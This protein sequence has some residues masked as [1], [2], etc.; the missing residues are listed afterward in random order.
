MEYTQIDGRWIQDGQALMRQ[1]SP[2]KTPCTSPL[3]AKT[4]MSSPASPIDEPSSPVDNISPPARKVWCVAIWICRCSHIHVC[5]SYQRRKLDNDHDDDKEEKAINVQQHRQSGSSNKGYGM[6][7]GAILA[8]YA[9]HRKV[10]LLSDSNVGVSAR[11]LTSHLICTVP[12]PASCVATQDVR[13]PPRHF[14]S[15]CRVA[16]WSFEDCGA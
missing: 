4:K 5:F 12:G 7:E 13:V 1:F 14:P 2:K 9:K 8:A 15:L 16:A 11:L 10:G 3:P 6:S